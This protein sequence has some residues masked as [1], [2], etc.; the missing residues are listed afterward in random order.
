MKKFFENISEWIKDDL[1]DGERW[2]EGLIVL[3]LLALIIGFFAV[4]GVY[5]VILVSP[6]LLDQYA[7]EILAVKSYHKLSL[8]I[9]LAVGIS[10]YILRRLSLIAFAILEISSSI[11]LA[12]TAIRTQFSQNIL[13]WAALITSLYLIVRGLDN[14]NVG[15]E[16]RKKNRRPAYIG[17][18]K[19][20]FDDAVNNAL[21]SLY[22]DNMR[23]YFRVTRLQKL[24]RRD[25]YYYESLSFAVETSVRLEKRPSIYR[26][27]VIVTESE[28]R[29][30]GEGSDKMFAA[31]KVEYDELEL[32]RQKL[33]W[34]PKGK[35]TS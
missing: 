19:V 14:F 35:P 30:K 21:R 22:F 33:V 16:T 23:S 9:F 6:L 13:F 12:S 20:G 32:E 27:K 26:A 7:D 4:L 31:R 34:G 15:L 18:S 10:T 3:L 29:L 24:L 11:V 28:K 25:K 5:V 8:V 2:K 17:Y 1:L